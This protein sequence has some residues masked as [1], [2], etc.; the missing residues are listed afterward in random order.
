MAIASETRSARV[1]LRMMPSD[2]RALML[3]AADA[4]KT[5]G[6]FLLDSGLQSAFEMLA[7]RRT[8]VLDDASWQTLVRELDRP[9]AGNFRLGEL[10]SHKPCWERG[11][12]TA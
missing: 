11:S 2:K 8:F 6:E 5:L 9:A 7:A 1:C 12:T 4:S 10:L 3:A